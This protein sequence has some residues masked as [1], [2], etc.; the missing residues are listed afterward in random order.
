MLSFHLKISLFYY[1]PRKMILRVYNSRCIIPGFSLSTVKLLLRSLLDSIFQCRSLLSVSLP[2]LWKLSLFSNLA[3]FKILSLPLVFLY[4][5]QGMF[6]FVFV[7]NSAFVGI[8]KAAGWL[9][10]CLLENFWSLT[11]QI[12]LLLHSLSS[13]QFLIWRNLLI[14]LNSV[15]LFISLI[16]WFILDFF[17]DPSEVQ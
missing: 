4:E 16:L 3:L 17:S 9:L 2:F 13:L 6:A 15:R 14:S 1:H 11:A 8:H 5:V 12:L 10:L 7:F